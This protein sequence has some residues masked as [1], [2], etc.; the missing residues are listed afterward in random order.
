MTCWAIYEF[1]KGDPKAGIESLV[2]DVILELLTCLALIPIFTLKLPLWNKQDQS[3]AYLSRATIKSRTQ[4]IT[5]TLFGGYNGAMRV[6]PEFRNYE[7]IIRQII[8]KLLWL[9]KAI[10]VP[11]FIFNNSFLYEFLPLFLVME[12]TSGIKLHILKYF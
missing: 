3:Y 7:S 11:I 12:F 8:A 5:G 4:D 10:Y 6:N 1:S 9:F 2:V